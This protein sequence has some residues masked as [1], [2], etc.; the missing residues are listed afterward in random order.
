MTISSEALKDFIDGKLPAEEAQGIAA[1]IASNPDLA[2]YV[3][4]QKALKS[5]LASPLATGLRRLHEIIATGGANWL[6]VAI[7]AIGIALGV[8]LAGTFGIATDLRSQ[9]GALIAQGA[10]AHDLSMSL[11][12][13]ETAVPSAAHVAA[14]FWSKNGAFCRTFL[15]RGNRQSALAGIACRERGAWRIAI[16]ETVAPIDSAQLKLAALPASVRGLMDNLIVGQPLDVRAER[17]ARSQ[18]WRVR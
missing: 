4:D 8:L 16:I 1:Q 7:M 12:D 14:S 10:L 17:Q 6:P 5:A 15:T 18:D 11:A 13:D 3:E 2:A 9:D